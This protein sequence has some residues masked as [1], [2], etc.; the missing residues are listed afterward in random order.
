M[1]DLGRR[2]LSN[3]S[4]E[5][6]RLSSLSI[7]TD[8]AVLEVAASEAALLE[9]MGFSASIARMALEVNAQPLLVCTPPWTFA[10][11]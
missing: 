11:L 7:L 1:S 6:R 10:I 9:D 3:E 5:D 4:D 8:V 2:L